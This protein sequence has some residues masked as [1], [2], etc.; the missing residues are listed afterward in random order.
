MQNFTVPAGVTSINILVKGAQGGKHASSTYSAGLGAGMR[1][2]F[3]VVPGTVL[4]VLV[5]ECPSITTGGGNGGG[6]GSFV[7][8]LSNNPLIIAGGGG[9]SCLTTSTS[10]RDGNITT[11]GG[12]GACAGGTGGTGGN[13]GNVGA[14]GFQ[15]G[16]GGGLLT[17][18][19]TGWAAGSAGN[20]YVSGGAGGLVAA[21]AFARG[22]YG[23]GGQ[24]SAFVVGGGGGGYSGG[25]GGGNNTP[26]GGNGGGGASY[27]IGTCQSNTTGIN[28]GHGSVVFSWGTST[29]TPVLTTGLVSGS[30]FP[31]GTTVQTYTAGDSFGNTTSCSFSVTVKDITT[32]T[33]TCPGNVSQCNPIVTGIA[34]V[35]V[36]DN[37]PTPAVTYSFSGATTGTGLNNASGSSFNVGNTT[38]T[39]IATDLS[40]NIGSCSFIVTTGVSP[41]IS[42]TAT[43]SVICLGGSTTLNGVGASTYTWSGGITNGVPFSP[44]VTTTY[45]VTGTSASGCTTTAVKTITV[46]PL[47]V[48]VTNSPTVCSGSN[49]NL[50]SNGG[51]G[52]AWSGPLAFSSALQNPTIAAA[53]TVMSGIYTVTVTSAAGCTATAN[54]SVSVINTPTAIL[55][56]NS[57]VCIGNALTFTASGGTINLTGPNGF[58]SVAT[59]PTI[60]NVT[61]LAAGTYTLLVTAGTCT[62]S[63]TTAVVI[64]TLPVPVANSNSPVCLNQPINFT[65]LG[66][67]TYTWTG[68]GSYSSTAQN[69]TIASA[70]ATNAGTYTLTVTNANG[71]KNSITTNVVI[72]PLPVIV[73]NSPTAC[74]NTNIN[75]SSN[76]GTGYTWSGPLGY[77]SLVQ[78]PTMVATSTLMT[79]IYTVTVTS[80]AGCTASA[81]SSVTVVNVPVAVLISNSPVCIGNVLTFTASGGTINLT[82]PNGFVSAATNPSITNITALANGTYS[83]LVTAGTC[84]ASTTTAVVINALPIPLANSNSPVCLNQPIIF[85]G[86]GGT[87]YTWT[88]PGSYS[89]T[90]QNPTIAS[91]SATNAGTYTLTVTNANGCKNSITT[92]VVVNILPII[93]PLNNPTVCLNTSINLA[94]NGGTG[95]SWSGP[96]GYT[97]LVQNPTIANATALMAGQYTVVVTSALGCTNSAIATV[98]VLP[99]PVPAITSNTPCVGSS[100]NLTGNG[101]AAYSW[102]GPNGFSSSVQ[103]PTITN[104]TLP[105]NGNYT[106][107]ATVGTCTASTTKSITVNPLPIPVAS[108]NAPI[109]ETKNLILSGNG[110]GSYSWTGPLGFTSAAQNPTITGVISTYSGNYILTVI[111]ANGCQASAT[112]AVTVLANPTPLANGAT[113][114]FGQPANLTASGGGSYSWTGPNGFTSVLPNPTIPVVNNLTI[115]NYIVMVTAANTCTSITVANVAA[116]PLPV[117]T[118]T[119]TAKTCLNTQVNL[120]GSPGFLMYQWTGPN[121]FLSPNVSTTFTATSMSQSGIYVLS[122]TDNNNCTGSVSTLVVIDPPPTGVLSSDGKSSCV[123]FCANFSITPTSSPIVSAIWNLNNQTFVSPTLN[124]CFTIGGSYPVR[125]SITDANGCSNTVTFSIDAYSAPRADFEYSPIKP[126]EGI[127]NVIFTNTSTGTNTAWNWYFTN[128]NGYTSNQ[129]NTSY[130]FEVAGTYPIAMVVKNKWG[131][132]DTVVKSIT[133]IEDQE[134]FVPNSFTPNGDGINDIFL[135]K[136]KGLNKYNLVV[137]DRWGQKLF[138]TSDFTTGWDGLFKGQDCKE[139]VY[140]WKITASFPQGKVKEY[141]GHVT[142]NR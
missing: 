140:V 99:L 22:G 94:S 43:N 108:N 58:V 5:G 91:A 57:P 88:G 34:P 127:D 130:L 113:V 42:A 44:T 116:N 31:V 39:Y 13:G 118:A 41:T 126:M 100:L 73:T 84:T 36:L 53:T 68:P 6:G 2:T 135:P 55:I 48:I 105:A 74:L 129:Q 81:T 38:V 65:G 61:A 50:T 7:T 23:C 18:G 80:A 131:C 60:T 90:A 128:N 96:L 32:P 122:V 102:S 8:D 56:S 104:V 4:K 137:F 64:N 28:V 78:N 63:T 103:N 89:S 9:G 87:T 69:A 70:S 45:T 106:L 52:Y 115:G 17:N 21:W 134:L 47:P 19:A 1:G 75:L 142:I 35:S 49:I 67:T 139:D 101:G 112:T 66:G 62:A 40:G 117:P 30:S 14:V 26:G 86:L 107:I 24:G 54:A 138:E 29:V 111:D 27:N 93:T 51:N 95:Y 46:N 121:N 136:G 110:G 124:Y 132:S 11:T 3:A 98:A 119:S 72:N 120:Q 76:G 33:I 85:T 20:S 82:G 123:P 12:T 109:C 97:S 141:T 77:T 125:A 71:C 15:S 114:C 133:I 83:L 25:G 16:A 79:G 37:C 10:A 92:N 59:N